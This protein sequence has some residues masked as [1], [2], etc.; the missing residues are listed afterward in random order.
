MKAWLVVLLVSVGLVA[1]SST[2][3]ARAEDSAGPGGDDG[4]PQQPGSG[5]S[6]GPAAS[7]SYVV[8][9]YNDLG[10]HC[11]NQDFSQFMVLP[12][13]NNLYAQV[14]SR[15]GEDPHLVSSGVTVSYTIPSNTHSADKTNFWNFVQ[16]LLGVNP[17]P[18]VG[19][20]GNG[21]AG[22]MKPSGD[23]DWLA[24]G[25][26]ITPV[27]DNG[28]TN[29]YPLATITVKTS[30]G[31]QVASTQAVVPVSW[32]MRC[33][34]CHGGQGGKVT[35][36]NI[37]Q[38]HDRLHGTNLMA[39]RPVVCG[40]CHAQPEL[41][42]SGQ[43]GLPNLSRAMHHAHASRMG[44][45]SLTNECY[46]CHPGPE[47]QCFRDVHLSHGLTCK[48]CHKSMTAV[49]NPKRTPWVD[50]PRC[51]STACHHVPGHQYEQPGVLYKRSKGHHSVHCEACHG[52]PHAITPT[53][54]PVDNVQAI[55]VQGHPGTIDTCKVCHGSTP[56]E[57]FPHTLSGGD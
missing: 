41:G 12:P 32:E 11:L 3:Y 18:N 40:S 37:L 9:G 45:V 20:T 42:L 4:T 10:M 53:V 27:L 7:G 17:A 52:S 16:A 57:P 54:V 22:N 43:P 51:G 29:P 14:I 1:Y 34:L 49:A 21:L 30:G 19:L 48:T 5:G 50:E 28:Q 15:S 31:Q 56:D 46:A 47:T 24:T 38:S 36:K 44:M 35:A 55:A 25:I 26:P 8:L 39:A 13:Y 2:Q 23:N 33:D 6:S